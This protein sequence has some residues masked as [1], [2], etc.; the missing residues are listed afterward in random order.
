[1]EPLSAL[2]GR[3]EELAQ[4]GTCL[5][6]A[7]LT[8]LVGTGGAGK[9]R[10]AL[11]VLAAARD[12]FPAGTTWVDVAALDDP[13]A[14]ARVVAS[15][16]G[17]QDPGGGG[18]LRAAVEHVGDG[19]ALLVLDSCEH[20]AAACAD[21]VRELLSGCPGLRVLATSREPLAVHGEV[22][23]P[24]APL[25]LPPG[26]VRS[27]AEAA[28]SPAVQLWCERAAAAWPGFALGDA[29]AATV[30]GLCR[31]LDGLPLA[32]E[33]AAARLR[34]LSL[35]EVADAL[36][37][38]LEVLVATDRGLP[39]RHRTLRATLEWSY[40]LLPRDEQR[41]LA[42]LATFHGAFTLDAADGVR[43]PD[44]PGRST[45]ELVSALIDRSLLAVADRGRPTRY[46]LLE[47]VRV[48]AAEHLSI[49]QAHDAAQ[50]H[51]AHYAALAHVARARL[52]GP[53]QQ[54]WLDL[55]DGDVADLIGAL[56]WSVGTGGAAGAS[57][58]DGLRLVSA[59]WRF[60]YLRGHYAVGRH[61][62]DAALGAAP[63]APPDLRAEALG[64]AG[65]FAYLQGD[66][67]LAQQRLEE[68]LHLQRSLGDAAGT[69]HVLQ[70]L[71]SVARERGDYARSRALHRDSRERWRAAGRPE[72]VAR[73]CNYLGFVAWLDCSWEEAL[74]ECAGA[75]EFFSSAADGEGR[76]WSLLVQGA[77]AAS[78]GQL[79][80]AHAL[81]GESLQHSGSTGYREGVAWSL[82]LLGVVALRE[83]DAASAR[84]LLAESLRTHW[85][86]GDRWR[87][88][89]VLDALAAAE[90]RAGRAPWAGHLLGAAQGLRSRLAVP[91]PGVERHDLAALTAAL[92]AALGDERSADARAAGRRAPLE[93]TVQRALARPGG[94]QRPR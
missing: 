76:A 28:R 2:V 41:L 3:A 72:E 69:A 1:P 38:R 47:S 84:D 26:T 70:S 55:L 58:E 85:Q 42:E 51:L 25:P 54:R 65:R 52:T 17:G 9:T 36:E 94:Q 80:A 44:P 82:N 61:W 33:L 21:L 19:V 88:A 86:L 39:D 34:V 20:L 77:V 57:P 48:F 92:L 7:R 35:E 68:A 22:L 4:V 23:C 30:A 11:A 6:R 13:A 5:R 93:H 49:E 66:Y 64:A 10:L 43:T 78:R 29:N 91:V 67:A 63:S 15:A 60:W 62:L 16:L 45:L 83:D 24:V 74:Q 73:S 71:G 90:L 56:Q 53:T 14:L 12:G 18:P 87:S 79:P 31:R 32:I 37:Q 46:R 50:R 59:L 40:R 27:A 89:S 81:L 75:L 8:T